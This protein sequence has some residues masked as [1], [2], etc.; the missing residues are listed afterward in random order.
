MNYNGYFNGLDGRHFE[1]KLITNRNN[2]EYTEII[3]AGNAPFIVNYN[4]SETP[5]DAVRTSTASINVVNDNYMEDVMSECA[6]GTAVELWDI[7]NPN[8]PAIEWIGWLTPKV[9]DAG[10]ENCFETFSLEAADCVSSLQY[11]DYVPMSGGGLTNIRSIIGQICDACGL[12]DGFYWTR[13]KRVGTSVL[14]PQHLMISEQ[15]FF[16][17]DTEEPWKLS[18]VLEELC[19]YLGFTCLQWKKRMY[20]IDYQYL[21]NNEDIYASYYPKASNYDQGTANHLG[22]P[23]TVT[24]D[25][26]RGAGANISFEPIYNKVVVNANMYAADNFFPNPF[27]DALLTN[28]VDSGNFYTSINIPTETPDK[29]SYPHGSVAMGWGQGYAEEPSGDS[30]YT[31]YERIYDNKYWESVYTYSD[32]E[33]VIPSHETAASSA[34]TKVFRGGT[35]VDLGV[36][37]NAYRSESQQLIVPSKMDFTRYL[38][39]N[40][41][42]SNY[43]GMDSTRIVVFRLKHGFTPKIMLTDDAFLV[44]DC[45][46]LFERHPNRNYINPSWANTECTLP[47][48][49]AGQRRNAVSSPRF[50]FHIGDMGWSSTLNQWV[51]AGSTGDTIYTTMQWETIK[52]D[53]WN[54]EIHILNNVSWE[55]KVNVEGIKIPLSGVDITQPI[56]FEVLNPI[57]G[58]TG[59]TGNPDFENVGFETNAYCWIKDLSVK[60]VYAGQD[61]EGNDSDVVYENVLSE[62]SVNDMPEI[63]IRINS[64]KQGISPSYSSMIYKLNSSVRPTF[65]SGVTEASLSNNA[66]L[67]EENIIEKYVHQYSTQ[68]KK[69]TL[70]LPDT[71]SPISKMRGVD[72]DNPNIA[73]V[74]LGT[75][76]DYS[77]GR[78]TITAIEKD[79]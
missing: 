6:Q 47:T 20:F 49:F 11:I 78:Q 24:A 36:V 8:A 12:L 54:R 15:N 62:C 27:D 21:E 51:P 42:Y 79:K 13:S 50:R 41:E 60:C 68:T 53:F 65:L 35:L 77:M 57:P 52:T 25:S 63:K 40:Q 76:I 74:Q 37:R 59:N 4:V 61:E 17:N 39:I 31:F 44:L 10:Y 7:T 14:M 72:V 26:Y 38:C 48:F 5:F 64:F 18:D 71:I 29:A 19:K 9:Y 34:I 1:V 67:P 66:Q 23:Y 32:G 43:Y 69:I 28:R 30:R 45:K 73:Y 22:V 2:S 70:T 56:T 33:E 58:F 3:L 75:E 46:C 55:D 16:S